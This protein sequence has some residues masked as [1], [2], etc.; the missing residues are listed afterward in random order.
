MANFKR[1]K[2]TLPKYIKMQREPLPHRM[3]KPRGRS[4]TTT[5]YLDA[6]HAANKMTR[7]FRTGFVIFMNRAPIIWYSKLRQTVETSTF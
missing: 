3:P 7:R 5:A 6:S 1:E 2:K 4:V